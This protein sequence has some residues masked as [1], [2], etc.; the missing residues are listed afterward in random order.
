MIDKLE[1]IKKEYIDI[2]NQLTDPDVL[3]D[4]KQCTILNKKLNSIKDVVEK[5][6][7]LNKYLQ[8]KEESEVLL[9]DPDMKELAQMELDEAKQMIPS[10]EQ[11]LKVL[12]LPKDPNDDKNIILEVRQAA[13]WDE[14]ALFA[15]ELARAYMKMAENIGCKT[16]IIS[17]QESDT[18]W[19]KEAAIEIRWED[20]YSKFKYES[21][22]H[23]VQR[24]PETESQGRVHT[25]TCTVAIMPD[26]SDEEINIEVKPEDIRLD[27]YRASGSWG[28]HVNK[29]DSAVRITHLASNIVVACQDWRSQ[30][31]NKDKAMKMLKT[32]LYQIAEE[33]KQKA[34]A[35]ERSNQVWTGDR[36]EKIRTYNFPQD[37]VTDHR[38]KSSWSNINGIMSWD[39]QD[40]F[41]KIAVED[42]LRKLSSIEK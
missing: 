18:G 5:Y 10:I 21:W 34:S 38:I 32:K 22:V 3:S 23:R 2:Q 6:S 15:W 11:E 39:M 35:D 7:E 17:W 28:Q 20:V 31:Q 12:L 16:S 29:T 41:E 26:L 24:I 19:L 42:E 9:K 36:S 13:W 8:Q 1:V 14:A 33:K 4:H 37:R 30:H 25:S 27:T 40:M